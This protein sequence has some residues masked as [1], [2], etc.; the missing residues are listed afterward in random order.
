MSYEVRVHWGTEPTMTRVALHLL[1]NAI[2]LNFVF[3]GK[4]CANDLCRYSAHVHNC[5]LVQRWGG[6]VFRDHPLLVTLS[7]LC[8]LIISITHKSCTKFVLLNKFSSNLVHSSLYSQ[9]PCQAGSKTPR[10]ASHTGCLL[11]GTRNAMV[12]EQRQWGTSWR[13]FYKARRNLIQLL[14]CCI[15]FLFPKSYFAPK[16]VESF[17]AEWPCDLVG[18]PSL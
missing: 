14:Y 1:S 16:Y 4:L 6:E 5:S 18:S 2:V 17:V 10:D 3:L 11:F 12:G 15:P 13:D 7:A 9:H 8:L